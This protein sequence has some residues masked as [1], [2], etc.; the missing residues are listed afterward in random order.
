MRDGNY[1]IGIFWPDD[2]RL[3][4]EEKMKKKIPVLL[5]SHCEEKLKAYAMARNTYK[6]AMYGDVVECAISSGNVVKV[7]SR[8]RHRYDPTRDVCFC[9]VFCYDYLREE[10][11]GVVITCWINDIDDTHSNI[12]K[13]GY[14]N[15]V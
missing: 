7:V 14:V 8:V 5:S 13:G 12:D 2:V 6:C 10:D 1:N 4:V 15:H 11:V 9:V 3:S